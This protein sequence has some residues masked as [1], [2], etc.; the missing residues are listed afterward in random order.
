MLTSPQIL[1]EY[2]IATGA[3]SHEKITSYTENISKLLVILLLLPSV[4]TQGMA[5][6]FEMQNLAKKKKKGHDLSF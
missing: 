2:N 3:Y 1:F 4:T 6:Y 5:L